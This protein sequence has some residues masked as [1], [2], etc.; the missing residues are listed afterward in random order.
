MK[1]RDC[2]LIARSRATANYCNWKEHPDTYLQTPYMAFAR[3]QLSPIS[4]PKIRHVFGSP[5]HTIL[6]EG[7]IA[8]PIINS[9]ASQDTPIA[10][11]KNIFKDLP[12]SIIP[13]MNLTNPFAYCLDF[14]KFDTCILP[15]HIQWF[16]QFLHSALIHD[17]DTATLLNYHHQMLTHV[18][19]LMPDGSLYTLGSGLASGSYFTQLIGSYVNL[20][21]MTMLQYAHF[22]KSVPTDRKSVV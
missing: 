14:S 9:L 15:I 8:S 11:G 1:K 4:E 10:I 3:T 21:L 22:G 7:T 2:Y 5:F 18:P 12:T 16:F 6:L 19:L 17:T 20:I 13:L